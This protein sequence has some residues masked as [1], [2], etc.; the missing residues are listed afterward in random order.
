[1]K[2]LLNS[3]ITKCH[4]FSLSR[5]SIIC[6]CFP[7]QQNVVLFTT[8]QKRTVQPL[9][10]IVCNYSHQV[11][12]EAIEFRNRKNLS[13]FSGS[14][15]C[16]GTVTTDVNCNPDQ[17]MVI[18][19]AVYGRYNNMTTCLH[20][21]NANCTVSVTRRVKSLCEGRQNC[22]IM[23]N[24]ELSKEDPCPGLQ[25]YLYLEYNCADCVVPVKQFF[26]K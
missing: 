15:T 17:V 19:N 24:N 12:L 21:G 3:V 16:E 22:T 7:Y 11:N 2:Q 4:K 14:V 9:R 23:V 26:G 25:N 20:N 1:M 10:I 5:R 8:D 6:I 18:Q 13:L